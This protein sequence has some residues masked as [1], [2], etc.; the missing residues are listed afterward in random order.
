[1]IK[2]L[3]LQ[4]I[5]HVL[6]DFFFQKNKWC[7][8]K[9][10]KGFCYKALYWHSLIIFIVSWVSI[11]S[12]SFFIPAFIIAAKSLLRY[13]KT[14]KTEYVLVGTL[15]SFVIAFLIG[16]AVRNFFCQI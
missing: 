6:G 7:E 3:L 1:M 10:K 16:V 9:G 13:N 11:P 14:D 4:F 5:A 12:V 8:P 2:I 15:L